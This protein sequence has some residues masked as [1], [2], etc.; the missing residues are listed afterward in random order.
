MKYTAINQSG[1]YNI[2]Y[3]FHYIYKKLYNDWFISKCNFSSP[4]NNQLFLE[5]GSG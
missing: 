1:K 4:S 3:D 2:L 5:C